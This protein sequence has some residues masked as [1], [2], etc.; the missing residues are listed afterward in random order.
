MFMAAESAVLVWPG[1]EE[2]FGHA[3]EAMAA[4][5]LKVVHLVW[6][7]GNSAVTLGDHCAYQS[8]D[9]LLGISQVGP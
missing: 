8:E 2:A 3:Y 7:K 4:R 5:G 1:K 9:C 6:V